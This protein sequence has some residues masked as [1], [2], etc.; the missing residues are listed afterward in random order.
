MQ[1]C[2]IFSRCAWSLTARDGGLYRMIHGGLHSLRL[3]LQLLV[4]TSYSN[5]GHFHVGPVPGA[6]LFDFSQCSFES[7]AYNRAWTA[8]GYSYY[9]ISLVSSQNWGHFHSGS[10]SAAWFLL[11]HLSN[12]L[13][14][15]QPETAG[16]FC[17]KSLCHLNGFLFSRFLLFLS[18][19]VLF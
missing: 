19:T 18:F 5:W 12:N 14:T 2:L 16:S 3:Q 6:T 13:P 17:D 11:M 8:T 7:P 9:F 4:T 15:K 10:S 1:S